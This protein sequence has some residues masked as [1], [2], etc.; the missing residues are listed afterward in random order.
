MT[1]TSNNGPIFGKETSA[2]TESAA[3]FRTEPLPYT[4]YPGTTQIN[5]GLHP[6]VM[7][8]LYSD[9]IEDDFEPFTYVIVPKGPRS[10]SFEFD[11][12]EWPQKQCFNCHESIHWWTTNGFTATIN[13]NGSS[14]E[15]FNVSDACEE[16]YEFYVEMLGTLINNKSGEYFISYSSGD[17][18]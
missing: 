7:E 12:K 3:S 14:V 8:S 11:G 6:G 2:G 4:Y 18:E 10:F 15:L 13:H 9:V 16:C 17:E 1:I 5:D